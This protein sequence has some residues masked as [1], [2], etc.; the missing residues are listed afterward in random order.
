MPSSVIRSVRYDEEDH[1]LDIRF[2]SGRL[3]TY[4]DVPPEIARRLR[5]ASSQGAF[6]NRAIRDRYPFERR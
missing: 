2:M 6:F 1:R 5:W 3:Y 4:R